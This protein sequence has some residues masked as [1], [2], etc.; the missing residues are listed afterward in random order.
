V[1]DTEANATGS[2]L[3]FNLIAGRRT[4]SAVLVN[5]GSVICGRRKVRGRWVGRP[6]LLGGVGTPYSPGLLRP[7]G[8][9]KK[10][11]AISAGNPGRPVGLGDGASTSVV[12]FQ[13]VY[14]ELGT[15]GALGTLTKWFHGKSATLS[16]GPTRVHLRS[17]SYLDWN[18]SSGLV[19]SASNGFDLK[20]RSRQQCR[21][22]ITEIEIESA[23]E[24][25]SECCDLIGHRRFIRG[26]S[27]GCKVRFS[28]GDIID[29]AVD[30][31]AGQLAKAD[32]GQPRN[33]G[34]GR[35]ELRRIGERRKTR[36]LGQPGNWS[37]AVAK[38]ECPGQLGDS[39]KANRMVRD[40]R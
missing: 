19:E 7:T 14:G 12:R 9:R 3:F 6:P 25:R 21:S 23:P 13:R 1:R 26:A 2:R 39:T 11:R 31:E 8:P 18:S 30:V 40:P 38:G 10:T 22:W 36:D 17:R 5:V 28:Q 33:Q 16:E 15:T 32:T 27:R 20:V 35:L 37:I 34:S 24:A 29:S 4:R